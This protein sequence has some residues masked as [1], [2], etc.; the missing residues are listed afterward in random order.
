MSDK[1]F[2]MLRG[3]ILAIYGTQE[4]FAN[5]MGMH[6]ATLNKKLGKKADWTRLEIEKACKLLGISIH[7]VGVYFSVGEL[8]GCNTYASCTGS[9][10]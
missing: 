9:P 2:A 8:Q 5:A 10:A 6:P 3:K 4:L 7:E 1:P